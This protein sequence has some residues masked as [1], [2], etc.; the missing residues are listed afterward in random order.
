MNKHVKTFIFK[1]DYILYSK[2]T[3]DTFTKNDT[4][5]PFYLEILSF[6]YAKKFNDRS[7]LRV[8]ETLKK[9]DL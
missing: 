8:N 1:K 9:E 6:S 2:V 4:T 7:H 3:F 5:F